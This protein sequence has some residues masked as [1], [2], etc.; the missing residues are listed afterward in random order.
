MNRENEL[1]LT[2]ATFLCD[3]K[4][5]LPET[6]TDT[7][8]VSQEGRAKR[9][10]GITAILFPIIVFL[11][12]IGWCLLCMGSQSTHVTGTSDNRDNVTIVAAVTEECKV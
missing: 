7:T 8:V 2:T 6:P 12:S 3:G 1:P 9:N 4:I 11:W 10:P 5:Y